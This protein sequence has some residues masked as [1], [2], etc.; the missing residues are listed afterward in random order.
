MFKNV[1]LFLAISLPLLTSQPHPHQRRV[2]SQHAPQTIRRHERAVP[3]SYIVVLKD[4]AAAGG[5]RTPAAQLSHAHGGRLAAI[6][7]HALKGFS[8]QLSEAAAQALAR[9]PSVAYVEED[10]IV[11][12]AATQTNAPWGL[13]RIDQRDLPLD[14]TFTYANSGAGVHAYVIDSGI[15]TTHQEFGGR[16]SVAFDNVGDS[17]NGEDCFG[18]GTHV[19]SVI[20]GQTF[21]VAKGVQLYAVRVFSCSNLSTVTKV[22]EGIDWVTGNHDSPAV[23]LLS[24]ST[25][26]STALDTAVYNGMDAGVAFVLA[27]GNLNVDASTKS[28]GRVEEALTVGATDASDV[29]ASFSNYGWV[30]DVF[31]PGV[32]IEGASIF[33]DTDTILRSGTSMA[34]AHV[35]GNVARYLSGNPQ[36]T[37]WEI[38]DGVIG[39]SSPGRVI[40]EG[41]DSPNLLLY[42]PNGYIGF[43]TARDR[44]GSEIYLMNA[45]GSGPTRLTYS[46]SRDLTPSV[47]PDGTKIVFASDRHLNNGL[48]G[49]V[50]SNAFEIYVMNIDGTNVQ[51]LTN[52]TS[53]DVEPTWSPD[54][55]Q[56][57][58]VA[59]RDGDPEIFRMNADGTGQTRVTNN[60]VGD[61]APDWSP[62]GTRIAFHGSRGSYLS[63][64]LVINVDGTDEVQLTNSTAIYDQCGRYDEEYDCPTGIDGAFPTWSPDGSKIAFEGDGR[65]W[66]MDSDGSNQTP[67]GNFWV[68][69][70]SEPSW[71]PDGSKIA[72]SN[73]GEVVVVNANGTGLTT[74]TSAPGADNSP[75]WSPD[76]AKIAFA[77][78]RDDM[79]DEIY[80]MNQGGGAVRSLTN[81]FGNELDTAWSPDGRRVAFLST[82][83]G[84][85]EIYVMNSDGTGQ[86]RLTNTPGDESDVVWSPDGTKIAYSVYSGNTDIF[87]MNADGTGVVNLTPNTPTSDIQPS[88]SPDGSKIAFSTARNGSNEIYTMNPNGTGLVRITNNTFYD[89]EPSWSPDGSKIAFSSHRSGNQDIYVMNSD[90]TGEVRI[91][92]ATQEDRWPGWSPDGERIIFSSLR[93]GN[94]EVYIMNP[95]GTGQT[96]LTYNSVFDTRPSWQ[97]L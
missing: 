38:Y 20:G 64:V 12:T 70:G 9:H 29:R 17:Q 79:G 83:D 28:P 40:N 43:E 33:S 31:A 45:D 54:G 47:S 55:T 14:G 16:A 48:G 18:H 63:D 59:H 22:V 78:M 69:Y 66:V 42:R 46:L 34:A 52:N 67:L 8:V 88:W 11:E 21:G 49:T 60:P 95:D 39:N 50:Y 7:E 35:A 19:A 26:P 90:G 85:R 4:E 44:S 65:L 61:S 77:T 36:T 72:F 13:D 82:R 76:S 58:F 53:D 87:V 62:D 24:V 32:D 80:L 23:A 89:Y 25:G 51:R 6:Y 3:N 75:E 10:G 56:I 27:A 92:T 30:L 71:S 41:L 73:S 1:S 2:P 57:A 94:H 91:T 93:H 74:L 5:V 84:N 86:T 68:S 37:P 96:R 97:P 81:H 15:R